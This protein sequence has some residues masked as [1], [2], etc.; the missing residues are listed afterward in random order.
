MEDWVIRLIDWGGYP[1]VFLL[2]L[3]ETLVVPMPSEVILPIAGMRAAN[4]PL[5]LPGVIGA[6][7]AGSMTG[8]LIWFLGASSVDPARLQ[9][10]FERHGRWLGASWPEIEAVRRLFA[11][12][13]A[14]LVLTGRLLPLV[15]TLV[16]IPAGLAR[17]RLVTYLL[18]STIGTAAFAAAFAGAGYYAGAQFAW[19]EEV[20]GPVSS[21][22]LIG[23]A[24]WYV[25]S[26]LTWKRR[27]ARRAA[28]PPEG[29]EREDV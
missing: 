15:R 26:Q 29:F 3:I 20:A 27:M 23:I 2:S 18:W 11:R 12:R 28:A 5:E 9:A 10:F 4:G 19:I 7:T 21:A 14:S 13:G 17:M 8:N 25:W 22:V 24:F 16:S 6:S 1:A